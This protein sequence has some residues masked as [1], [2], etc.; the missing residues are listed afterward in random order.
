M[1]AASA[2]L[3]RRG[4]ALTAA[5]LAA[6]LIAVT[7]A[8]TG[9]AQVTIADQRQRLIDAR[10]EAAVAGRRA[11]AL[12][13]RAASERNAAARAQAEERA[14][15]GRI[16]AA[17]AE[18]GAARTRAALIDDLLARRRAAL[19]QAQTPAARLLAA[20]AALARRP[21]IV[22]IAQPGSI[23]DLVHVRAVLGTALPVV[24][25]RTAGL[26]TAIEDTRRLRTAAAAA[27][28]GL[29]DGRLRLEQARVALAQAVA[30]HRGRAVRLGQGAIDQSDRALALG[31][32]ARDL[33]DRMAQDGTADAAAADLAA[34]PGPL[35]RP[36]AP[37]A[38]LP[39]ITAAYRLP[40]AGRLVTGLGELSDAGVRARGLTFTVARGASV[41]APAAGIVRFA[42]PFRGY[43][44]I[45]IVDHGG[46][47]VTLITGLR[48]LA[49]RSGEQAQG[50][51]VLGKAG[52]DD[53]PRITVELRRRGRPVDIAAL[54]G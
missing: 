7:L 42:R 26:R 21:A 52:M 11:D 8:T 41:V 40:V 20:L 43:G 1:G 2:T 23:D 47:W 9:S 31:E 13:A 49:V 46:G 53:E 37:G 25:A 54:I 16:A 28:T 38:A 27:A 22:A 36:V 34:I 29:R 15:A 48:D 6:F 24:R 45:V 17:Q 33:V 50:G 19:A 51:M 44:P 14:L 5:F 3:Q 30:T 10:R 4:G 35:P 12:A 18:L 39:P 32:R